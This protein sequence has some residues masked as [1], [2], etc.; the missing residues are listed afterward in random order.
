MEPQAFCAQY[1]QWTHA[2]DEQWQER[3]NNPQTSI[4]IARDGKV[5]IGMLGVHT[6]ND[7]NRTS[8][9]IWGV[10]VT[11]R[12][13]GKGIGRKLMEEAIAA[14]SKM[15]EVM[16]IHLMVNAEQTGTIE[17]YKTLG[18]HRQGTTQLVLGDGKKHQL[19]IMEKNIKTGT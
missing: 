15:N 8:A 2:T 11:N 14:I 17:F 18:F 10:Y 9:E 3:Q 16:K 1:S 6:D 13:R 7:L 4:F 12:Y 19:F 5:P